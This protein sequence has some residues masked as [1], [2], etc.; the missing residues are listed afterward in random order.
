RARPPTRGRSASMRGMP[1]GRGRVRALTALG[2]GVVGLVAPAG[3]RADFVGLGTAADYAIYAV[4]DDKFQY[5]NSTINGDV[6]LGHGFRLNLGGGGGQFL[7]GTAFYQA[8]DPDPTASFSGLTHP[9]TG[10]VKATG[11]TQARA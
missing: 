1:F 4:Q 2:I 7:N 10:G 8:G 11:L 5:N 3:G 6:A 9:P